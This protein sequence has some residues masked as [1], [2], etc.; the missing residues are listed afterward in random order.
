MSTWANFRTGVARTKQKVLE[1]VG[2]ADTT[3]NPEFD[4]ERIRI[5]E[6]FKTLK[7]INKDVN[8][9]IEKSKEYCIVSNDIARDV[10][11]QYETTDPMHATT[12]Q[13][14]DMALNI[15]RERQAMNENLRQFVSGPLQEYLSQF[16][17]L[18]LRMKELD[19]RR[20]DM[21][22]YHREYIKDRKLAVEGKYK[23]T[24]EAY[25]SLLAEL[26]HD[27]PALYADRALFFEPIV[28]AMAK[29]HATFYANSARNVSSVVPM[30]AH[31]NES[32]ATNH[33]RTITAVEN[34]A[35]ARGPRASLASTSGPSSTTSTTTTSRPASVYTPPV[36][37]MGAPAPAAAAPVSLQ[38]ATFVP[39]PTYPRIQGLYDFKAED[40]RELTFSKGDVLELIREDGEWY[41]A[42]IGGRRGL[43][44]SNYVQKI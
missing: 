40:P 36:V 41:E 38:K 20:L 11:S 28:A 32:G 39:T 10:A 5:L 24:K 43:I 9:Y 12:Q 17:D 31:I 35:M 7:T 33:P 15:D 16:R 22:R 3:T 8:S 37:P 30:V 19:V 27:I 42:Q 6:L 23:V 25:E 1:K 18:K 26:M 4:A 2:S 14:I 29:S 21:D 13:H 34:S 44:P